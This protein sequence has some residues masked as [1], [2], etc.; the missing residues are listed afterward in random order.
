MFRSTSECKDGALWTRPV[1]R[2]LRS[3]AREVSAV[4][5]GGESSPT[6]QVLTTTC[7]DVP[8]CPCMETLKRSVWT[9]RSPTVS[10]GPSLR[11]NA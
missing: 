8:I 3:Q 11:R 4:S 9:W 7:I 10:W 1:L 6:Y 5:D 2:A